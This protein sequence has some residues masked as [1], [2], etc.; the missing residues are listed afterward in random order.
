MNLKSKLIAAVVIILGIT[1]ITS[2]DKSDTANLEK[3]VIETQNENLLYTN[4]DDDT[5]HEEC[6]TNLI[7]LNVHF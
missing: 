5:L 2:C 6:I 3:E 4:N 7:D 1:A